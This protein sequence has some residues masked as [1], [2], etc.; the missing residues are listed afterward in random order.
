MSHVVF[1]SSEPCTVRRLLIGL[2]GLGLAL[3]LSGCASLL[4]RGVAQTSKPWA[5]FNQA[6]AAFERIQPF[7][8]TTAELREQGLDPLVT[9][10]ITILNYADIVRRLLPPSGNDF[11]LDPGIRACMQAQTAC[12]GFEIEQRHIDRKRV[13]NF[14]LDFL[15]FRRETT[16]TGWRFNM[17]LLVVND[18]VVYKLWGGQPDISEVEVTRNPLGP[19]QGFGQSVLGRY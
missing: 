14:W 17:L 4:P 7:V 10:N 12:R 13:G 3:A 15:D 18:R 8:T 9:P 5:N 11:A 16:T 1:P 2:L 6:H 19:L